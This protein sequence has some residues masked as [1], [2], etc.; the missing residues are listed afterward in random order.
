VSNEFNNIVDFETGQP[1]LAPALAIS[2]EQFLAFASSQEREPHFVSP[3]GLSNN[4]IAVVSAAI[5][6][7][8]YVQT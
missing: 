5:C 6:T 2:L 1:K 8:C 7:H 4:L 3:R